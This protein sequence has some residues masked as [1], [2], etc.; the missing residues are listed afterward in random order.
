MRGKGEPRPC[1]RRGAGNSQIHRFLILQK[2]LDADDGELTRTRNVRRRHIAGKYAVLS[3]TSTRQGEL[4]HRD[5]DAL[6][7]R[8][9]RHG[10]G[11]T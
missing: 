6:R 3:M 9:H 1:R 2:E 8:P 7:G 5:R 4:L 10:I 11:R